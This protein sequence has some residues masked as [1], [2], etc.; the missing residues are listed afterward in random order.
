M[1]KILG[2]ACLF[3]CA[4]AYAQYPYTARLDGNAS[5]QGGRVERYIISFWQNGGRITP[6]QDRQ[7]QW[8]IS[9][10]DVVD[11]PTIDQAFVKWP[12]SGGTATI[13]CVYPTYLQTFDVSL[14]VVI[15]ETPQIYSSSGGV[16]PLGV[17]SQLTTDAYDTYQWLRDGSVIATTP[18]AKITQPGTYLLRVTKNGAPLESDPLVVTRPVLGGNYILSNTFQSP[19]A[20]DAVVD[21]VPTEKNQ[22]Q[23]QYFDGLGRPL[24]NITLQASPGKKDI[25]QPIQYDAYGR[26]PIAYLPYV[27][28]ASDG[29]YRPGAVSGAQYE[30]SEHYKFYTTKNVAIPQST[31]AYTK[32]EFD[33][34]PLDRV[35]KR[36]APGEE[37]QPQ[38][39]SSLDRS[40]KTFFDVN[41]D[42]EVIYFRY[43]SNTGE[44]VW[45]NN[46]VLVYYDKNNLESSRVLDEHNVEQITFKNKEGKVVLQ[47]SQY[48]MDDAG[49]KRYADTYY[50]YDD[51]GD[52][53]YVLPP[54]AVRTL[55]NASR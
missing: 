20:G 24:Q 6:P 33:D 1:K 27:S 42:N 37:Y 23:I 26:E 35:T 54:E 44:L 36:G 43:D 45:L 12:A 4:H 7:P 31:K 11:K 34:S 21:N 47:R 38:S 16:L 18:G 14:T 19:V 50:V 39:N 55:L 30:T 51:G 52:L 28:T 8:Y 29:D 49:V 41:R 10:G 3:V 9:M 53:M 13:R 22:R 2:L 40:V 25:V 48:R 17:T 5:P 32:S 46:N 15:K